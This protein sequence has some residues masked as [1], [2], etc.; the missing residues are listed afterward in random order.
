MLVLPA[1]VAIQI[2]LPSRFQT[3]RSTQ[4]TAN[5]VCEVMADP[6]SYAGKAIG[7]KA[8]YA[9]NFEM[10]VLVDQQ[11]PKAEIWFGRGLIE[12]P[13]TQYA[14]VDSFRDLAKIKA[15]DWKSW[16]AISF[17][18]TPASKHL[19]RYVRKLKR[20]GEIR[21]TVTL[22]GRFDYFPDL[23]A[24]KTAEGKIRTTWGFGH[25]N[26]CKARFVAESITE[27][28]PSR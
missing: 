12:P 17:R 5:S 9:G 4:H 14:P 21:V 25:M 6:S 26:C 28:E 16:P 22:L 19:D 18:E 1:V 8:T 20:K 24:I 27:F 7:I 3:N 10:S 2:L 15:T 23:L 11:C 13:G